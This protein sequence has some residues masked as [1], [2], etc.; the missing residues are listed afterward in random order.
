[1]LVS[2][3]SCILKN[4]YSYRAAL[5]YDFDYSYTS[6]AHGWS[7]G[8]TS[9]LTYYVLGLQVVTP[10]GS[11]WEL[12][13]HLSGLSAAE[14]GFTTSLGW[15]G[16]SWATENNGSDIS[17]NISTPV[18]TQ[19]IVTVPGNMTAVKLDG[20]SVEGSTIAVTG[21]NHTIVASAA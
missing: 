5:G 3:D 21:G 19:G 2:S 14:G 20:D 4:I 1:M 13:P 10:Q 12:A 6:H 9:A 11:S 17:L 8:P 15:F 16:A 18:G 7:T